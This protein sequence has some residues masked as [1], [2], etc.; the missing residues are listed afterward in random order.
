MNPIRFYLLLG[1]S[2]LLA[3]LLLTQVF[4]GRQINFEQNRLAQAQQILNQGQTFQTNLKALA[5]R[6]YQDAQRTNDP[7][8]KELLT[9]NQIS[10]KPAPAATQATPPAPAPV[11]PSPAQTQGNPNAYPNQ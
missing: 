9:R 5:M 3:A 1:M 10:F 8:L 4:I 11:R 2:G 6:A 7:G